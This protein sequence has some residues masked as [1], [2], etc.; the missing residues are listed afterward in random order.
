MIEMTRAEKAI[1]VGLALCATLAVVLALAGPAGA[2]T[3]GNGFEVAKFKIEVKGY[4][5]SVWHMTKE[6]ADECDVSDHSF[7]RERVKFHTAKPVYIT[8]THMPGEF[9]P[10]LFGGRQLG[11]PTVAKVQRNFTAAITPPAVECEDNGGGAE[12]TVPDCGTRTVKPWNLNL[13]YAQRKKNALLLSGNGD[14]DPYR[15]CP[16]N[17]VSG[18]PWLLVERSGYKGD[19]ISADLSQ[20]ELFDPKFQKWISIANGSAKNSGEG[21]WSQTTVHWEVSFTRLKK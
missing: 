9:N 12:P 7:G 17:G 8:A 6:A 3:Y 4:E 16:G 11:I 14:Q 20:D 13:Q 21:W 18:F 15:A 10:Q 2:A 1:A 19:Y 5:N